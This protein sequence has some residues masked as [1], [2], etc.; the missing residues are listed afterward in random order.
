MKIKSLPTLSFLVC[1]AFATKGYAQIASTGAITEVGFTDSSISDPVTFNNVPDPDSGA[2][3]TA[4]ITYNNNRRTLNQFSVGTGNVYTPIA[5]TPDSVVLRRSTN[6]T[7]ISNTANNI[8]W[9]QVSSTDVFEGPRFASSDL[10]FAENNMF[11]GMDNIIQNTGDG[12]GNESPVQRVDVIFENGFIVNPSHSFA[13]FERGGND[14]FRIAAITALDGSGNPSDY[15]DVLSFTSSDWG[16]GLYSATTTVTRS[17]DGVDEPYAVSNRLSA[18]NIHGINISVSDNDGLKIATGTTIYGYSLFAADVNA[19]GTDLVDWDNSNFF[20]LNTGDTSGLD[21]M[22]YHGLYA[23]PE[24]GTIFAGLAAGIFLLV[25][26]CR[27]FKK[28]K[29]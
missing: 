6:P 1:L 7:L 8:V 15:G 10:A 3:A 26:L 11:I 24:P 19:T 20:P 9:T 22:A 16:S 2:S 4:T 29:I 12:S 28:A 23:I 13:I 18:Q 21:L 27:R 5:I 14:A 25:G 17:H